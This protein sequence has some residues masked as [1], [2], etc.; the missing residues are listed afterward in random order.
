MTPWL[1]ALLYRPLTQLVAKSPDPHIFSLSRARH[2]RLSSLSHI[3]WT[4]TLRPDFIWTT[5]RIFS[6]LFKILSKT[7]LS[8]MFITVGY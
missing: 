4:Y 3:A 6:A 5:D 7:T 8:L 2:K 1:E